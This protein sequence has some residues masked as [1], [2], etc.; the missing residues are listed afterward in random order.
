[1]KDYRTF[2][3]ESYEWD[4]GAR[5][6]QLHYSLD[7]ELRLTETVRFDFAYAD[8]YSAEALDRVLRGLWLA[9]GVSYYKVAMVP[10]IVVH[11]SQLTD[12]SAEF[13]ST[14]YR[15]GLGQLCYE[16]KL[17]LGRVARFGGGGDVSGAVGGLGAGGDLLALGGGK[18]SLTSAAVLEAS[19]RDVAT[20]SA[21]YSS[22]AAAALAEQGRVLGRQHLDIRREFDPKLHE[23]TQAGGYNGHVPVTA[24]MMF[25]GLA[26]AVLSGR[27]QVIFSDESSAGEGNVT[28]EGVEINHQYS[29]SLHFER[30]MQ[31]YVAENISPDV[32]V[33]SLLRPL[34]EL[35]IAQLFARGPFERFAATFTS[36]NRSFRHDSSGFTWC[37]ECPKCAF[38]FLALAPFVPKER[39]VRLWGENLLEKPALEQTY[40]ELLG[41]VGHKPFE[42]VG[43]IDEC[44]QAVRMVVSAYPEVKR[45]GVPE[46][47]FDWRQWHVDAMP[48]EYREVLKRYV[49]QAV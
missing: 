46:G 31:Q 23:L 17:S 13:F 48:D 6:V 21:V 8:G 32:R 37:G 2:H 1:M 9:A 18:D 49:D 30:M 38:V 19:G 24:I 34:G 5:E 26:A 35:R 25:I 7:R 43:E 20:Y 28:Y 22:S 44:R 42:C 15:L 39:L 12:S 33:F 45:F 10:E 36:C 40:R 11:G 14:L 41:L 47:S 4:A 3:F 16:N 27:R 29:K